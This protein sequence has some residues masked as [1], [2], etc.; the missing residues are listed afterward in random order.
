MVKVDYTVEFRGFWGFTINVEFDD[1]QPISSNSWDQFAFITLTDK[2]SQHQREFVEEFAIEA[3]EAAQTL[4]DGIEQAMN[5][6]DL[7]T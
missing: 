6:L 5:E 3:A 2:D 1:M 4:F 7:K